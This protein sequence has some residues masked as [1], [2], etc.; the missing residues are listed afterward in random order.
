MENGCHSKCRV[1]AQRS[2]DNL[3]YAQLP[4]NARADIVLQK[5]TAML[6]KACGAVYLTRIAGT[7]FVCQFR[8]QDDRDKHSWCSSHLT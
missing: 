4:S 6:C 2:L 5:A 8:F 3:E 1:A 7:G